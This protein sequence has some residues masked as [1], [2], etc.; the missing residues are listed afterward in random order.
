V[1]VARVVG[2]LLDNAVRHSPPGST[3]HVAVRRS[4]A[5]AE[6]IVEDRGPGISPDDL[7]RI[8][9]RFYRGEKSRS[10]THGGAGLGLAIARGIIDVHGGEIRAE[11]RS[12]G[13]ARFV[14]SLPLV[15]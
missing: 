11:N 12:E 3:V 7:E 14:C 1:R 4:G 5:L 10:R 13:G 8:F 6:V 9:S 2:N 15:D